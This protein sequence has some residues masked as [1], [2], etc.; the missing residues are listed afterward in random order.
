MSVMAVSTTVGG[1]KGLQA[2]RDLAAPS[3]IASSGTADGELRTVVDEFVGISFFGTLMRQFRESQDT[4]SPFHGG[5]GEKIFAGQLDAEL[6][7]RIGRRFKSGLGDAIYR[8]LSGKKGAAK[9]RAP[10]AQRITR[11]LV[12]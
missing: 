8:Q 10:I 7:Q 4:S 11:D 5:Q 9:R 12:G 3:A 6:T 2:A 1:A